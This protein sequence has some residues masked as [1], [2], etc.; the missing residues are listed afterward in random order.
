M[1]DPADVLTPEDLA[2]TGLPC[3]R[4]LALIEDAFNLAD[5][6]SGYRLSQP[7]FSKVPQL[8]AILRGAIGY[9]AEALKKDPSYM[10]AGPMT[11]SYAQPS[12]TVGLFPPSV[13][14]QIRALAAGPRKV[15]SLSMGL[16]CSPGAR[17][18]VGW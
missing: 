4:L 16:A 18:P 3:D 10:A 17:P 11:V 6:I 1:A 13:E 9:Y 2:F 5:M 8:R 12:L 14:A 15:T 7:G